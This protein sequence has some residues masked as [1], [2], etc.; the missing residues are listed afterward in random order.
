MHFYHCEQLV[1]RGSYHGILFSEIIK[2]LFYDLYLRAR[3]RLQLQ[4]MLFHVAFK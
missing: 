4:G 2:Y 3:P 1:D